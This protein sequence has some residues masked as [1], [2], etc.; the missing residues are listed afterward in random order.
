MVSTWPLTAR[1]PSLERLGKLYADSTIGG[2][3]LTG[4][5]GVGK[6]RLGEEALRSA[7]SAGRPT[8]RA[9]GHPATQSIPLGA[10]AHMLPVDLAHDVG[11]GI[12]EDD[13][14]VLFHGARVSLTEQ[15]GSHRLLLMV[16]DVDQLD[17]TS[18]ALLLP[19]MIDRTVFL[20]ATIRSGLALP[21][22]IASLVKDS[23]ML[24]ERLPTLTRDE[25]VTLLYRVLDGPVDTSS[26]DRLAAVSDG[27]LQVLREIVLQAREQGVLIHKDGVWQLTGLPS[28][29]QL[30]DLVVSHLADL[31]LD[32]Q[33]MLEV[34]AVARTLG[35]ADLEPLAPRARSSTWRSEASST[36]RSIGVAPT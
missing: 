13:R 8:A 24:L 11:G 35:L 31:E 28:S 29:A 5:A 22:V 12:G 18:L 9:V 27:N 34:L 6:T 30:E 1:G 4:P 26:V 36:S 15:A 17:D 14:A 7:A 33:R 2:V 16:D 19:L 20:V 23:H 3:V 10:L 21:A 32:A 25:V